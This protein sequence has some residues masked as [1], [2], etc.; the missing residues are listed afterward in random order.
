MVSFCDKCGSLLIPK[1][2]TKDKVTLLCKT[3]KVE[4]K[5]GYKDSSYQVSSKIKHDEKDFL[6]VVEEEFDVRPKIRT[7]CPKCGHFEA[8]YWEAENR[9]KQEEWETTTYY[10]C[11]KCK[12]VWS[13]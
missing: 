5:E 9:K 4:F 3:C 2:N 13:E 12:K 7:E 1:R 8:R 11:T 10:K 6:T